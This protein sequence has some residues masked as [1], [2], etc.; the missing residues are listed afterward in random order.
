MYNTKKIPKREAIKPKELIEKLVK[1][2]KLLLIGFKGYEKVNKKKLS[3]SIEEF[4]KH[5]AISLSGEPTLYPYLPELIK[6]LKKRGIESIFLVTNGQN[7]EMLKKL[8]EKKAFPSQ[9]YVSLV[10][11]DPKSYTEINKG[12][13]KDGFKALKKSLNLLKTLGTRSVIRVTLITGYNTEKSQLEKLGKLIAGSKTD[14]VEVKAYMWIGDS[15]K[16][17]RQENMPLFS[18]IKDYTKTILKTLKEYKK[19]NECE[20]SRIILL[21]NKNSKYKT[22]LIS[23]H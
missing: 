22:K 11:Y 4:P 5:W 12:V 23:D 19:E 16:K 21:K 14:F 20:A 15:R 2:R 7:P 1:E 6:E 8:K 13:D 17:L 3:A 18:E 10:A 9:L